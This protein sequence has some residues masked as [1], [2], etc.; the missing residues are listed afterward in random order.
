MPQSLTVSSSTLTLA[1]AN[2]TIAVLRTR[3]AD[4]PVD[5]WA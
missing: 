1:S 4:L 3:D 5:Q 2:L